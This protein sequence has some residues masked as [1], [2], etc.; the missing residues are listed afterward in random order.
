MKRTFLLAIIFSFAAFSNTWGQGGS[1]CFSLSIGSEVAQP[2]SEVCLDV[3]ARGF[4]DI[5]GMQ[6]TIT[7]DAD[8]LTYTH[9]DN[10]G[11]PNLTAN[12]FATQAPGELRFSWNESQA[13]P[14]DLADDSVLFS[15]CFNATSDSG[16][17]TGVDFADDPVPVEI[18]A[19]NPGSALIS[20][21]LLSGAVT[22]GSS[23]NNPAFSSACA[24]PSALCSS[25]SGNIDVESI[26]GSV[27]YAYAWTGPDS[28]A[29]TTQ[30]IS[31]VP[32]GV[33]QVTV[34][35]QNGKTTRGLFVLA[36]QPNFLTG[37]N[38]SC[39]IFPD[40]TVV[41]AST[42]VWS[43]G[44][45]PFIFEWN[46][47]KR[48]TTDEVSSTTAT[49]PFTFNVTITDANGCTYTPDPIVPDCD[50][51]PGSLI[52]GITYDCNTIQPDSVA[53]N[54]TCAVWNGTPPFTFN[55]STGFS[56][57]SNFASTVS[58]SQSN[59]YA[60]TVTDQDGKTY[61]SGNITPDCSP[62]SGN[63]PTLSIGHGYAQ[64]NEQVCI[65]VTA[66]NFDN[67]AS[68]QFTINWDPA[69]L[70]LTGIQSLNLPDLSNT[71]FNFGY[72]TFQNGELRFSW[73]SNSTQGVTLPGA[74]TLFELCFT[75]TGDGL[76]PVAFTSSPVIIE[77]SNGNGQ[78]VPVTIGNGW[79]DI[80]GDPNRVWPGDTDHN[81]VVNQY[82][83]L[84]IGLA[85]GET[86]PPR[87]GATLDWMSQPATP[88]AQSTPNSNV[89]YMHIDADGNG[90]VN[91]A[92]TLAL[93]LN[94]AEESNF[95]PGGPD[96]GEVQRPAGLPYAATN[97]TS[98]IYVEPAQVSSGQP[99]TFNII[100]GASDAPTN[101]VYGVA[102][103]IVYDPAFIVPGSPFATFGNSW[104]GVQNQSMITFYRND[105]D[106][107]RIHI[108]VTRIDGQPATG[109]G[110]IGELHVTI[111][112]VIFRGTTEE[113]TMEVENAVVINNL[114]ELIPVEE[115]AT[116]ST[117]TGVNGVNEPE[118]A[119]RIKAFPVPASDVLYLQTDGIRINQVIAHDAA[120]RQVN[121]ALNQGSIDL[122]GLPRGIYILRLLTDEGTLNLK[123]AK[124]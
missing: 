50:G 38:Y 114:E 53:V 22:T 113:L 15:I 32:L 59:T 17:E 52:A 96:D 65:P 21:A 124:Q 10:L 29:N 2:G 4:A 91:A 43:G 16:Q 3:T 109:M 24:T 85:F 47:G 80:N 100:L 55:W 69:Q 39:Q 6:F 108:A 110:K 26:G 57:Q 18:I 28:Y 107:N 123:I 7:W 75:A 72:P 115:L 90:A 101:E 1:N 121:V 11:L 5:A 37:S 41:T 87:T 56:E 48:D 98:P 82:D 62:T 40:S 33:Y 34:T 106:H 86:G 117:V 73:L 118:L 13:N 92:D 112:D 88:W 95:V 105:P 99:A 45:A 66:S 27:P 111:E 93:N 30:D 60:V 74:S 31:G 61:T 97:I 68:L 58:G 89:N 79:V 35:D 49:L 104:I 36:A 78:L 116:T 71:N 103:T 63:G 25:T 120:G 94:W 14:V 83:L 84:P 51:T 23:L 81:G 67:I 77:A 8:V 64:T 46:T 44:Q 12:N 122:K 54:I 76:T 70:L 102:F 9:A 19:L 119:S 20:A 42:I